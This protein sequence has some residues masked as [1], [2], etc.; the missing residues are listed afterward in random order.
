MT[1]NFKPRR[2]SAGRGLTL[3]EL[4]VVLVIVGVLALLVS[5]T[6]AQSRS[7]AREVACLA[8]LRSHV[9]AAQ[10]WSLDHEGLFPSNKVHSELQPYLE[11]QS[12]EHARGRGQQVRV[13]PE[14]AMQVGGNLTGS[15]RSYAMNQY[16][17]SAW[18]GEI[19]SWQKVRYI[20]AVEEPADVIFFADGPLDRIGGASGLP[21]YRSIIRVDNDFVFLHAGGIN[22]VYVDGN[23]ARLSQ[24]AFLQ[25]E[26]YDITLKGNRWGVPTN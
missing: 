8:N 25:P 11:I 9:V 20:D 4:L 15:W 17:T 1:D 13:C 22:V 26:K 5:T 7:K 19:Y 24:E 3:V 12:T 21:I 2:I 6:L 23:A 10:L 14:V 18:D 16:L